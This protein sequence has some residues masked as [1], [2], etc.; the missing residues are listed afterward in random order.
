MATGP[1]EAEGT[2]GHLETEQLAFQ[3]FRRVSL[4]PRRPGV[5]HSDAQQV[6]IM[7]NELTTQF[8]SLDVSVDTACV[9]CLQRNAKI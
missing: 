9:R 1:L 7:V 2:A 4:V 6:A 5:A 8:R 3:H